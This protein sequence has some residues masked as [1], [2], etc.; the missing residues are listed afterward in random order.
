MEIWHRVA[1]NS[2]TKPIFKQRIDA[3]GIKYQVSPLPRHETGLIYF[4]I[5][6]FNPEWP[7]VKA[8]IQ[9]IGA[10]DVY[11][12]VFSKGEILDASWSRLIPVFEQ[13]YPLPKKAWLSGLPPYGKRCSQCGIYKEQQ[14]FKYRIKKEPRL[15]KKSFISLY[16]TYALFAIPS[17]FDELIRRRIKGFEVWPVL[18]HKTNTPA[19]NA[20]QIYVPS[21]TRASMVP[22]ADLK[23]NVCPECGTIKYLPH[24]RGYMSFTPELLKSGLDF[25]L[26]REWF[27][28]GQ[29]AYRE[30]LISNRMARLILENEWQGVKLKPIKANS[31][32]A[33]VRF[34]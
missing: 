30:I 12:T 3:L 25:M 19:Q 8:Q 34:S 33:A 20:A 29:T 11:D 32:P 6:E 16:W 10:S 23:R 2:D 13:G 17:V 14:Q 21:M 15:G 28:D 4:D 26:S 22:E 18:I 5:A 31:T 9:E 1:F 7:Q 27:G 24:K